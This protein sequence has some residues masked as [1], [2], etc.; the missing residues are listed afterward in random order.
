MNQTYEPIDCS[1]HDL[2]LA[3]ATLKEYC[4]IQYFTDIHEFITLNSMI[5]DVFT[6]NK[7]EFMQ[8][9]TDE[10]IRL[11]SIVSINGI[12]SPKYI[13]FQDFTCDC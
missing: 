11:D 2:L 3:K 13:N 12:F 5:K 4:K 6:K 9:N 8:L 10:I 1:F 7:E